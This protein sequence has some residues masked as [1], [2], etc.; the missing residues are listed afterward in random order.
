MAVIIPQDPS[1]TSVN[2]SREN[3]VV[4]VNLKGAKNIIP[5]EQSNSFKYNLFIGPK[6]YAMLK[7]HGLSLEEAIEFDSV[8]PGLKWLSIGLLLLS[9]FC[10]SS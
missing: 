10:I 7:K 3:N 2:M 5:P 4:S 8:I 6:D 1:L 9:N